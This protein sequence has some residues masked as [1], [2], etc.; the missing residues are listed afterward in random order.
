MAAVVGGLPFGLAEVIT[1]TVLGFAII[2]GFTFAVDITSL[3]ALR[4]GLGWPVPLAITLAYVTAFGLSYALNR[5]L[6][7]RSHAA[8]GPQLAVY[9]AVVVANYLVWIM[10]LGAGLAAVGIDYR[11]SRIDAGCGEAIY[12]YVAMRWLV[13][14]D[15]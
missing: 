8:V 9:V 12:M 11:V 7:F 15:Q 14:R 10:C 6:N 3:V 2:N 13:F 1:P 5:A 4:S